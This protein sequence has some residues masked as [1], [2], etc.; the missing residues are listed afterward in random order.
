MITAE[1]IDVA[2]VEAP[3]DLRDLFKLEEGEITYAS[4]LAERT[5]RQL[6]KIATGW[7]VVTTVEPDEP[8]QT[9]IEPEP[10]EPAEESSEPIPIAEPT[11]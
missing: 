9:P 11:E 1:A 7:P 2:D 6:N 8:E 4:V 3:D 5:K 10:E